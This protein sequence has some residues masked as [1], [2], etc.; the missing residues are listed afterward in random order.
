M[1]RTKI[2]IQ[3]AAKLLGKSTLF[4]RECMKRGTLP[5]G[6]AEKMPD[7]TKWTFSIS[8]QALADYIGVSVRELYGEPEVNDEQIDR[9]C[10]AFV[11]ALREEGIV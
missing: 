2:T 3:E 5:I 9:L 7:S 10:R 1:T 11:K 8:P 4:V 6:T